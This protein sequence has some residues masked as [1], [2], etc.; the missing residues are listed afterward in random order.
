[1][2]NSIQLAGASTKM[3]DDNLEALEERFEN[4]TQ[5]LNIMYRKITVDT[6]GG[7]NYLYQNLYGLAT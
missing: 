2:W 1:M 3:N 7:M 6:A 5:E 4:L